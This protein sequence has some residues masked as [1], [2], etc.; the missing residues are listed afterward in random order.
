[1][2]I[3]TSDTEIR[4][5]TKAWLVISL[6]FGIVLSGGMKGILGIGF[7]KMLLVAGISV[8]TG[9]LLH[10]LAHKIVAQKY[11]CF[12]EFRSFDNMLFLA[13][14]MSFFGFII[15]APGAVMINGH[16]NTEKNGKISLAGPLTNMVLAL[17]FLVLF[18]IINNILTI[19]IEI[20]GKIIYYGFFIN[21]LLALFNLIPFGNFDGSKVLRWN[22]KV[23]FTSVILGV[24]LFSISSM[25]V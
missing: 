10:E 16:I 12:A 8:G 25:I 19:D 22:K 14:A 17:I 5:L 23:Y 11:G 1:M 7:F 20:I 24:I 15:A 9:F 13:L 2:K 6:A 18:L 3:A 21:T 4:D